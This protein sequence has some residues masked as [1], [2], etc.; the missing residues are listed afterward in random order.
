MKTLKKFAHINARSV[1]SAVSALRQYDGKAC[2]VAGGTDLIGT[3]RFEILR[4]YPEVVINLKTVKGLDYIKEEEGM[5]KIGALTRLKDIAINSTIKS[6]YTALAEAASRTAT[7]HVREMG[8]IA[9]N[10]CQL[11]R[12]WYFRK[13]DNTFDC[14]RKGGRTC[15]AII[16]ENRF[17][18]IFGSMK[19]ADPPCVSECPT[20]IDIPSYMSKIREGDLPEAA[21]IILN[22]NPFPS[23]TGRL[24]PH[25]CEQACNRNGFDEAVSTRSIE[26]FIGDYILENS[27]QIIKYPEID[28]GKRVAIIGSGPAG[29]SAA[30]YLRKSGHSVTVFDKMKEPGGMLTYAIPSYRLP[31][32]VV[33]RQIKTLE[34]MGIQFKLEVN[35]GKDVTLEKLKES[36]DSIFIACGTSNPGTIGIKGEELLLTGLEFLK[37]VRLGKVNRKELSQRILVIGGGNVAIDVATVALRLGVKEV[38]IAS[39]ETKDKMPAFKAEI[40]TAVALGAK[41]MPSWGPYKILEANGKVSGLELVRCISV[42]DNEGKFSP[43]F[44]N[45]IRETLEVDQIIL[46]TGQKADLSFIG[47]E[48]PLKV[49]LGKLA[50]NRNTQAT[51][52]PGV[53]A[54]GD[55]TPGSVSVSAAF[56]SGRRAASSIDLYL[57]GTKEQCKEKNTEVANLSLKFDCSCLEK[58][59]R[60]I[61]P[62]RPLS[63]RIGTVDIE[64]V[65]TLDL[66]AVNIEA[67]R[68][69]NCG[70]IAVNPS[71]LA[72]ALVA[73]DAKIV[74]SKRIIN[75]E[76]FWTTGDG[77]KSTVLENDEVVIEI[78]LPKLANGF[79]SAFIKFAVR[80]SIDFPI[81]NCAV[82]IGGGTARICLNAVYNKP[83]RARKAEDAIKNN[84]IDETNAEAAS[85]SA[86][87]DAI[88]LNYNIYKIQIAKA[89]VKRA[90][91]ACK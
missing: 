81:V 40:E 29:L 11:N 24:C 91:L 25:Y 32:G 45:N 37:N 10:I 28:T 64:D 60:F 1:D 67:N 69:F 63:E 89:I 14:M 88:G 43:T 61:I 85:I 34:K 56:A 44:D 39:L 79:K 57:K 87:S 3:M 49:Q 21:K 62:E 2:V 7:P 58:T 19:V 82:G 16:G 59:S 71:D 33:R 6:K 86:V 35:V 52:I 12:C 20:G 31:E 55:I 73:L 48:H 65:D 13:E 68:C 70:C 84:T 74:T 17:H 30:F 83:Y 4:D 90:I 66:N 38:I 77:V 76:E 75:A 36:F 47:S 41:L 27:P 53:F 23:I 78:Q 54:G 42:F 8:T 15:Y 9:G 18:S 46:A 51:N 72:P 5:I 80:K 26:R 22:F 50:V